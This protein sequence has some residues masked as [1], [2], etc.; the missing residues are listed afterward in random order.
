MPIVYK[1]DIIP[2]AAQVITL[3]NNAGL[4]RPTGDAERIKKMYDHSNLVITAWHRDILVGVA[5]CITD[6]CWSCYLAD[7]AVQPGYQ[8][9]GIGKKLI[10]LTREKAGGQTMILLLS[11][12][13][14]MTYY[15]KVGFTK[16]DRAFAIYRKS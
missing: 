16:E 8:K 10:D 7:L 6:W 3:Y 13:D 4:P 12:P 11:V 9:E 1:H 2:T 5:R 15:P 14:A